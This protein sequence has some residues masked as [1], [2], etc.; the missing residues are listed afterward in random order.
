MAAILDAILNYKKPYGSS[1]GPNSGMIL[2]P[3]RIILVYEMFG[4]KFF[5]RWVLSS[6]YYLIDEGC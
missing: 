3:L 1:A 6:P 5:H 2:D 4:Y